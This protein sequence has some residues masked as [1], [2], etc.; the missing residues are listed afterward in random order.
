MPRVNRARALA[1]RLSCHAHADTFTAQ[2]C[3]D[4]HHDLEG[5]LRRPESHLVHDEDYLDRHGIDAA[6]NPDVCSS[7]HLESSCASCHGVQVAALPQRFDFANPKLS[8]LHRAGFR[9]RHGREA[10]AQRGLCLTCHREQSCLSCHAASG[11]AS[12]GEALRNPHPASGWVGAT[13]GNAHGPA[14]RRDPI[15]CASCHGGAGEALCVSCH[16]V[17]GVGGSVH[18]VG[19]DSALRP[20]RDAPCRKCHS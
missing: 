15:S 18:P 8:G 3:D 6:T 4:C 9:S 7:C 11:L 19:F 12:G 13:G 2:S 1:C 5:E 17:G 20:T 10:A 16:R 14:A